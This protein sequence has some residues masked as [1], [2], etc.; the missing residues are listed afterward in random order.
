MTRSLSA[1]TKGSEV[2]LVFTEDSV[3]EVEGTLCNVDNDYNRSTEGKARR[4]K[5]RAESGKHVTDAAYL[6]V[7]FVAW[8]GEGVTVDG[9]HLY[10]LLA[11]S[12]GGYISNPK[13]LGT[14]EVLH[15]LESEARKYPGSIHV[16]F[17]GGYDFNCWLAD[18]PRASVDALYRTGHRFVGAYGVAWMQGKSFGLSR[19][20]TEGQDRW[21]VTVYDVVSF[22]QCSFVAACDS[23]L[24]ADFE[25]RDLIV[26]N[27]ALR[28]SFTLADVPEVREYNR[29]EL[30]NL[31]KLMN[32]L[33]LRLNKCN[34]RPRR[35]HGPGALAATLLLRKKVKN[36]LQ[37]S[38]PEVA[39]ASRH[40]YAGGRFEIIRF[41][42][43]TGKA[44][45]YDINSAYPAALRYVPNLTAGKWVHLRVEQRPRDGFGLYHVRFS[46]G[47]FNLPGP[48]FCRLGKGSI[49]YPAN[50]SG[51]YWGPEAALAFEYVDKYARRYKCKITCDESWTFVPDDPTDLPFAFIEGLYEQR[52]ALKAA[53][54]GAHVGLKLALNSMYGKLAQQVGW[55]PATEDHPEKLPPF[56]QLEWAG[57]T[58]AHARA[59]VLRAAMTNLGAVIAFETD[60][61]FSSKPLKVPISNKLGEFERTVFSDLT[62]VQSGIYFGTVD[63]QP[64][65]KTRGMDRGSLTKDA[66][67]A[68][69]K[70]PLA[71]DRI[72]RANLTRF[73][74]AGLALQGGSLWGKWRQWE[75]IVKET[76]LCYSQKR[77]HEGC[78]VCRSH[79]G[80]GL[81]LE[82]WHLTNCPFMGAMQSA[83]YPIEWINPNPEMTELSELRVTAYERDYEY[84]RE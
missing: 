46:D 13:G 24:G 5:Y 66:T 28:G 15:F 71:V 67:I 82:V 3:P 78:S 20:A 45:E 60:A 27:K 61:V 56:H 48:L 39:S 33:R 83:E 57:F 7:P 64:V 32:E 76:K 36:A 4:R 6:G 42:S 49:C 72:V 14:F 30:V 74:G 11:N 40:A 55:R 53:G 2:D 23:Y 10:V 84:G 62:Y 21:S 51:W 79:N 52:Q 80:K 34:L 12:R 50:V 43:V 22:F 31:V 44:Y 73:V 81:A 37:K 8:D 70:E 19:A 1:S 68:A 41:G 47:P 17:G 26:S 16:I 35:W 69:L 29:L 9:Q 75:V 59:T 54:D 25:H 77:W 38:P 63:G 65:T 58:T 18:L